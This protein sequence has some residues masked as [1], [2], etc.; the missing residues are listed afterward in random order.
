MLVKKYLETIPVSVIASTA[1][2]PKRNQYK[3]IT[4]YV[5]AKLNYSKRC[6]EVLVVDFFKEDG[7]ISKRFFTDGNSWITLEDGEWHQRMGDRY[8]TE[9]IETKKSAS[10]TKT[11][12]KVNTNSCWGDE[13]ADLIGSFISSS[14]SEKKQRYAENKYNRMQEHI[15]MFPE[16]PEGINQYCN[17]YVFSNR[18]IVLKKPERKDKKFKCKCLYCGKSFQVTEKPKHKSTMTCP[19]CKK[20]AIVI[21]ERYITSVKDKD[22]ILVMFNVN[23]NILKEWMKIERTYKQERFK[24]EYSFDSYYYE[25]KIGKHTYVYKWVTS[26]WHNDFVKTKYRCEERVHVYADNIHEIYPDGWHRNMNLRRLKYAGPIDLEWLISNTYKNPSTWQLYKIGLY[27]LAENSYYLPSGDTFEEVLRVSKNYLPI[28]KKYNATLKELKVIKMADVFVND[29]MFGKL[30]KLMRI[31]NSY[32]LLEKMEKVLKLMTFTKMVNYFTKQVPYYPR[33]S[34]EDWFTFYID[35]ISMIN[36]LNAK[37]PKTKKI[38]LTELNVRFPK[39]LKKAHDR[40]S[41]QLIIKKNEAKE[42]KVKTIAKEIQQT[43]QFEYKK[44]M[45]VIPKS[46]NDFINEGDKLHHCVGSNSTYLDQHIKKEWTI[47]FIRQKDKPEEPFYT[48]TIDNENHKTKEC[49]GKYHKST[50]KEI[51]E[52]LAKYKIHLDKTIRKETKV[53]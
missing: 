42:R 5:S 29:E 8:S 14:E 53:A 3:Q 44:L 32:E 21:A 28:L 4:E 37:L 39:D 35:Y 2:K 50:T 45:I 12:I 52:F 1:R 30:V 34:L 43:H 10:I 15:N 6:G 25:L 7:S 26:W 13:S 36:Q 24:E 11:F 48:L 40:V 31:K 22:K 16:L 23:G 49:Q 41:S 9:Y 17:E 19:K 20:E 47:L 33:K 27:N 38:D 51:D 18:Y 46:I